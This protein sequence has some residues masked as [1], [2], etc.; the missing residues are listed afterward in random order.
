MKNFLKLLNDRFFSSAYQVQRIVIF[1]A[2]LVV[3]GSVSF[4]TYYYFD[5][6]ARTQ[7]PISQKSIADAEAVVQQDPNNIDA[8]MA[9]AETYMLYMRF[10]DA[11]SQAVQVQQVKPGEMRVNFVLGISYANS[12]KPQL[13]IEP[14]QKFIDSRQGEEMPALDKQ[15]QSALYYLGDCYLQLNQPEQA[16]PPLENDVALSKTDAD[17]MYKLG[18]AYAAIKD[19]PNAVNMFVGATTFV[20]DYLEAYD[21]MAAAY[22]AMN[23]PALATYA[24]GMLAY[25]KKDYKSALDLLSKAAKDRPDFPLIFSGLG[26]VYE[27]LNDLPNAKTAYETALKL[28]PNN[29][30]AS[31]GIQRV[32]AGLKK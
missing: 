2:I 6:R 23:E 31:I 11:I 15:L 8:R 26:R 16:I 19:Y 21:A 3:A 20:P 5:R 4:G 13:A 12:S 17:A 29:F 27:S 10:D 14:L 32:E 24:R 18:T 22:D 28:D 25:S 7:Q 9:L 30:A 1:V